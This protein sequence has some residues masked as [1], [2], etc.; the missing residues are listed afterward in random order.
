MPRRNI[1]EVLKRHTSELMGVPGVVGLA[2]GRLQ[3]KPCIKVFVVDKNRETLKQLPAT[4][5]GYPL[6]VEESG[7][8]YSATREG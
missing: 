4:I 6:E 2:E 1:E 8:F 7:K 5:E 3:G